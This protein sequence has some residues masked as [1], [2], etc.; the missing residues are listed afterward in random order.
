MTLPSVAAERRSVS[1]GETLIVFW[2]AFRRS[3]LLRIR[4]ELIAPAA[5]AC[6]A[7][8]GWVT[9]N[10]VAFLAGARGGL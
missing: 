8:L 2:T 1:D 6:G 4:R 9:D 5:V 3:G 10:G 7:L